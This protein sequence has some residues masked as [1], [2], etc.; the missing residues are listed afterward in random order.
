MSASPKYTHARL[1]PERERLL[2][3][4]RQ[5]QAELEREARRAAEE[6]RRRERL[7]KLRSALVEQARAFERQIRTILDGELGKFAG[8]AGIRM[9]EEAT[10]LVAESQGVPDEDALRGTNRRLRSLERDVDNLRDSTR[11][12]HREEVRGQ[13]GTLRTSFGELDRWRSRKFDTSG[14]A[15]LEEVLRA[16][17]H[18][19]EART[20]DVE[21]A[22][23]ALAQARDGLEA[24][25]RRVTAA[26]DC[27][28]ES[29]QQAEARFH[30]AA[31]RV[32]G[33][34][35]DPVV[36][37]WQSKN[38]AA[39]TKDLDVAER[40]LKQEQFDVA[41]ARAAAIEKG[42]DQLIVAAQ[43]SQLNEE[44]RQQIVAAMRETLVALGFV[45]D[46]EILDDPHDE[47][48]A[49]I[50]SGTRMTGEPIT[51]SVPHDSE[52]RYWLPGHSITAET[53]QAG[54]VIRSTC[55]EAETLIEQVHHTL[56]SAFGV[57]TDGIHWPGKPDDI[58][59]QRAQIM[60]RTAS[61]RTLEAGGK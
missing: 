61:T 15:E 30:V 34:L 21:R 14:F 60:T 48:S 52:V 45:V 51:V 20:P 13:L 41:K 38:I 9:K 31:D 4:E 27:W 28:A 47:G 18:T 5:R 11:R 24:H 32:V 58:D 17:E 35:S 2:R 1:D 50:L 39:L 16:V 33:V 49:Y 23:F 46:R 8:D 26:Y 55:P 42:V 22:K 3:L 40:L 12:A 37:R 56:Q 59:T 10:K 19:F 36:Q 43:A 57:E 44:R 53:D 6:R 29:K 7:E 54:R 25:R